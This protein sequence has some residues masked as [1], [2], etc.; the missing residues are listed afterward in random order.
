M[1]EVI[2]MNMV[3]EGLVRQRT[4]SEDELSEARRLLEVCNA[5]EGLSL[6]LDVWMLRSRQGKEVNDFLYYEDGKLVGLLALDEYGARDKE[7]TGMVLPEYRRRGIFSKLLAA[8]KEETRARGTERFSEHK[9]VLADF[10]ERGEYKERISLRK[11]GP[12]DVEDLAVIT[13]TSFGHSIEGTKRN[14]LRNMENPHVQYY[15]GKR[16]EEAVGCLNL[17]EGEKEFGIYAFAVLLPY[18][19]R[20]FGRQM[21]ELAIKQVRAASEKGIALEVETMNETAIGLY[22]SCGFKETTTYGYYTIDL[23]K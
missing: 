14:I 13:A 9:M 15:L 4:W 6:K 22:R 18:R 23:L 20:G 12:E 10:K 3:R 5:F 1:S 11:A 2:M 21:L 8:A 17:D 16:G 7:F 19:R